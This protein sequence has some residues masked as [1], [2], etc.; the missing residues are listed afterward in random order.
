MKNFSTGR[1]LASA[2]V[3]ALLVACQEDKPNPATPHLTKGDQHFRANEFAAAA[4]EYAEA[5]K[6]DPK[7]DARFFE[8]IALA[9]MRSGNHDKTA[10]ML[11][12]GLEMKAT[13]EYKVETYKNVAGMYLQ[14][15]NLDKAEHW[16]TEVSKLDP[17]DV[18][19][20]T[21]LAEISSIRGGARSQQ[22]PASPQ[23]LETA[24]SRY[25]EV[26]AMT[27]AVPAPYINKRIALIKHANYVQEQRGKAHDKAEQEKLA[28]LFDKLKGR[29]DD[30]TK[31]LGEVNKAA[32]AAK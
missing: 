2:A 14:A 9:Y 23:H 3:A 25:D 1:W 8:K 22:A 16:Y 31:K 27:P 13:P 5:L 11:F 30:T 20:M 29:L 21:W 24:V 15:G 28:A 26:I 7:Q 12:K 4:G 6:L 17:K 19:S 32:R 10:E 18:E